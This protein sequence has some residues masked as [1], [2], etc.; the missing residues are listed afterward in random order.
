MLYKH[1][2]EVLSVIKISGSSDVIVGNDYLQLRDQDAVVWII[3]FDYLEDRDEFLHLCKLK[4]AII[5][6][7]KEAVVIWRDKE[8]DE[9]RKQN[10]ELQRK[11]DELNEQNSQWQAYQNWSDDLEHLEQI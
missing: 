8:I 4:D 11:N 3:V 1:A 5:V 9:L 7:K 6:Y 2:G 10:V